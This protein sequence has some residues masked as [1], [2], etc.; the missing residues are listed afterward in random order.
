MIDDILDR[1]LVDAA[2]AAGDRAFDP[3]WNLMLVEATYN[4]IHTAI[5]SGFAHRY[6]PSLSYALALCEAGRFERAERILHRAVA[7]QD[8]DPA[9]DTYGLWGYYAEEPVHEMVPPDW[10]QADFNGRLLSFVLLRHRS[11][12]SAP[13]RAAVETAV[14]HA[15]YSII[16]RNVSMYYTN[17]AAKGTFVTLAAGQVLDD[18][19]L[20]RYGRDR[21]GRLYAVVSESGS[22][23]EYNSPTYWTITAEAL[24][25]IVDYIDDDR[26]R[27]LAQTL[28]DG[29]WAHLARHWHAPSGQLAGPMSR[30]YTAD[31]AETPELLA[32]LRKAI[33][34]AS[35]FSSAPLPDEDLTVIVPA[36]LRPRVPDDLCAQ[37]TEVPD[38]ALDRELF[39]TQKGGSGALEQA[40]GT[41]VPEIVGCT[42]REPALTLGTVNQADTWTQR[43]NLLGYWTAPGDV[44]WRQPARRVRLRVLKDGYDFAAGSFSS[45]QQ[46]RAALW[47]VSFATPG[48]DRHIHLDTIDYEQT[49]M[50]S[51]LRVS[52]EIGGVSDAMLR[53]NGAGVEI[54]AELTVGDVVSVVT[55]GAEIVMV[56]AAAGFGHAEPGGRLR[57]LEN[58]TFAVD[59]DLLDE[60]EPVP[61][62]L[63]SLGRAFVAGAVVLGVEGAGAGGAAL[64]SPVRV[65]DDRTAL[66]LWWD[67]PVGAG[68][69]SELRLRFRA[70]TGT[71]DDHAAAL[72]T[73]VDGVH[74]HP[75]RASLAGE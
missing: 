36:V 10:N 49:F 9:S 7:D 33:E 66:D 27:E 71:R 53:R 45:V 51:S 31:T 12:L 15:A 64:A 19:K 29:A 38:A 11:A 26:A 32:F 48:G 13:L 62:D 4:P 1:R 16:R 54:G 35:P 37:F 67:A 44:A 23:A 61:V 72:E 24:T 8:D 50:A 70:E 28:M 57:R 63:A 3:A 14:R 5:V 25:A 68:A 75:L 20:R 41:A 59:V 43:R 58:G 39:V 21:L 40:G 60:P 52:L 47:G 65:D 46:G 18:P 73:T 55:E 69:S 17:I 6:V 22:F 74:P 2:C 56:L 34:E 30:S 42:W